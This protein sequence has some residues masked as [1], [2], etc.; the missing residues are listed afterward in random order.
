MAVLGDR[1]GVEREVAE[2]LGRTEKDKW[3]FPISQEVQARAYA[4]LGD[5][6]RATAIVE[7]LLRKTYHHSLTT[8]DLRLNPEW[9]N[10]R[11][12][13]RFQKLANAQ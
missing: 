5:A 9:D 4:Q 1:E 7:E 6:A 11:S 2:L 3:R 12:D 13:G 8:A 10:I